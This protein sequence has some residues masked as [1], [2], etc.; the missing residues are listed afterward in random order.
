MYNVLLYNCAGMPSNTLWYRL[1]R[2]TLQTQNRL[3][4]PRN[5]SLLPFTFV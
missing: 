4:Q 5:R 2:R 1:T 3:G